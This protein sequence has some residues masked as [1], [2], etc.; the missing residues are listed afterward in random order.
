MSTNWA[1]RGIKFKHFR[2][3]PTIKGERM[4]PQG[5]CTIAYIDNGEKRYAAVSYCS[6]LDN[7]QFRYGRD[8]AA[9]RLVQLVSGTVEADSDKYFQTDAALDKFLTTLDGFMIRDMGYVRP[10]EA[11]TP[12]QEA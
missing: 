5:G 1:K 9:G 8:K 4:S 3:P 12:R 7:F 6:P 10:Y 11:S 2:A